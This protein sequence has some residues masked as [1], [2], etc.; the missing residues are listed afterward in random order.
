MRSRDQESAMALNAERAIREIKE[1]L[2]EVR[3]SRGRREER[4]PSGDVIISS[5]PFMEETAGKVSDAATPTPTHPP[6]Y[7]VVYLLT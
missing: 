5:L 6:I 2:K 4:K 3:V 7:Y 1:G